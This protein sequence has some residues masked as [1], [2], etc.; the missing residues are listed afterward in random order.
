MIRYV[1]PALNAAILTS[2]V[3]FMGCD[4]SVAVG[5]GP[6]AT[7]MCVIPP[8]DIL[9]GQTKDGIPALT[10]PTMV[11]IGDPGADYL[12][13]EERV[14]GLMSSTGPLAI[15]IQILWWHEIVNIQVDGKDLAVS[16]CPLT[17]SSLAFD[18]GPLGG[19]EF[20]VSGLLYRNNLIMY[21]RSS[22]ESLWPQ[23]SRGARCGTRVGTELTMVPVVEMTWEGWS[24]LHPDTRVVS[25]DTGYPR[26]YGQYPYG[27]YDAV[28][29][30]NLLFEMPAPIDTRRQPK[31]RVLGVPGTDGGWAYPF[32]ELELAGP[33][34]VIN[35]AIGSNPVGPRVVFWDSASQAAVLYERAVDGTE[36]TFEVSGGVIVDVE[37]GSEWRVDGVSSAGIHAGRRL[38]AVSEAYVAYWFAWAAFESRTSI[39]SAP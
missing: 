39:W 4:E 30:P 37:T 27:N 6:V 10:D 14:I 2:A 28:D 18:R 24:S 34:A 26:N 15:P 9:S 16:H 22:S 3:L 5:G 8:A 29:N 12:L 33:V 35:H 19:A 31:E 17:G 23:L 21:D 7:D 25:S 32:E 36:L 13:P 20:G 1:R 38:E 11:T